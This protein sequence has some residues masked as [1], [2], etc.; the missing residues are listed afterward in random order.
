ML[1]QVPERWRKICYQSP[2]LP[3]SHLFQCWPLWIDLSDRGQVFVKMPSNFLF[4]SGVNHQLV[5]MR[6]HVS[7]QNEWGSSCDPQDLQARATGYVES[8]VRLRGR[9]TH[10]PLENCPSQRVT[11]G[12]CKFPTMVGT[13]QILSFE[14]SS[15]SVRPLKN[16]Q[17]TRVGKTEQPHRCTLSEGQGELKFKIRV[18]IL[19]RACSQQRQYRL[20]IQL[21]G[22][23]I[24]RQGHN[25]SDSSRI[26]RF[27]SLKA[28]YQSERRA[29][30]A[31]KQESFC[32]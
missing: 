10:L 21:Q 22:Q 6:R 5:I 31:K 4:I 19:S 24:N 11:M 16:S 23:L 32:F 18:D 28:D 12:I 1:F 30:R 9:L 3:I 2:F 29:K 27:T 8:L 7:I 20:R 17:L 15:H 26:G 25:A 14:N 13:P